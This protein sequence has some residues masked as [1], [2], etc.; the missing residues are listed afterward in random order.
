MGKKWER[1]VNSHGQNSQ[2]EDRGPA[3]FWRRA[4]LRFCHGEQKRNLW[5]SLKSW[6]ERQWETAQ[7]GLGDA[8]VAV[9]VSERS[10]MLS[11]PQWRK[12]NG[13]CS[14]KMGWE[15]MVGF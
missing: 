3:A 6:R 15:Q 1:Q 14:I 9:L 10:L 7:L 8:T 12:R 13:V 11:K 4:D 2:A 5:G